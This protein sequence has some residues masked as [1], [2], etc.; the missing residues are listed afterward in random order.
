MSHLGG[1]VEPSALAT[2]YASWDEIVGS[3]MAEHVRPVR[4]DA[5]TLVVAVD[6]PAW[7]TKARASGA[8]LLTQVG[9]ITGHRP[10]RLDVL[11]RRS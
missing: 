1:G 6:H 5:R 9:D 7:A 2:L 4:M 3:A 10:G 11:V 8:Q